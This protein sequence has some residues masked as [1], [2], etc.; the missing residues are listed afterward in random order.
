M[1]QVSNICAYL[2]LLCILVAPISLVVWI[3]LAIKKSKKKKI[4]MR[5]FLGAL[6]GIVLFTVIGASTSPASRCEHEWETIEQSEPTC[7]ER[8][9]SVI[10]CPLCDT[11]RNGEA[12]PPTGH[13]WSE[14]RREPTCESDGMTTYTCKE[15]GHEETEVIPA[16][17]HTFTEKIVQATCSS[18]GLVERIC[19]I[20]NKVEGDPEII[21]TSGHTFTEKIVQEATCAS[22][23]LIERTCSVCNKVESVKI[24]KT[25]HSYEVTSTTEPT[26]EA[27][28]VEESTCSVCGDITKKE[29]AILGTRGNPGK[30][31]V[32]E[33]V[34]E[35]NANKNATKAKYNG[36]WIEIT[37][38]VLD[39]DTVA[40]MTRFYLYG[41]HGGTSL[42][43]VCWVNEEVLKP[44]SYQGEV[45]TFL[46]QV[47]EIS[48]SNA[49]E[50]G[51]CQ[52]ISD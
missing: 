40:G 16:T 29:L 30:V 19:S 17:G 33:L 39:A 36:K 3:V 23:G 37:G 45:H 12:V 42:R 13:T 14:A 21:P 27:P 4:A 38:K 7:T 11:K 51:D 26:L 46:G 25:P 5:F 49:T 28:G 2:V 47:R 41:E 24:E 32:D 18:T 9:T 22:T 35:I 20:C 43:I 44:F 6:A 31:T 10:Y 34:A 15:C 1:E 50:I 8:G 48:T 52:I